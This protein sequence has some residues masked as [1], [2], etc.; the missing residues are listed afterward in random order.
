MKYKIK[1]IIILTFAICFLAAIPVLFSVTAKAAE[2]VQLGMP[3]ISIM[4]RDHA[5]CTSVEF[6]GREWYVIAYNGDGVASDKGTMTLLTKE[7]QGT[8]VF[9]DGQNLYYNDGKPRASNLDYNGST[10]QSRLIKLLNSFDSREKEFIKSRTLDDIYPKAVNQYLWPLSEMEYINI[11]GVIPVDTTGCA[12]WWLRSE[13][14][15]GVDIIDYINTINL[16]K[17]SNVNYIRPACIL[18]LSSIFLI[19]SDVGGKSNTTG[20]KL[21]EPVPAAG[22]LKFT[23]LNPTQHLSLK[24]NSISG[25][26]G[27]TVSIGYSGATTGANQYVSAMIMDENG[28]LIYYGRLKSVPNAADSE[29]TVQ[30]TL[31]LDF[32]SSRDKLKLFSEQVNGDH[33][34]DFA[35]SAITVSVDSHYKIFAV[36]GSGG[37]ISP[38]GSTAV[39]PGENQIYTLTP[40]Q[41]YAVAEVFVDDILID[42]SVLA[43]GDGNS[44][45]YTFSEVGKNHSIIATFAKQNDLPG[46]TRTNSSSSDSASSGGVLTSGDGNSK[47][48]TSSEAP[49]NRSIITTFAKQSDLP[50]TIRTNASSF[51]DVSSEGVTSSLGTSSKSSS[52]FDDTSVSRN[53]S[54][55]QAPSSAASDSKTDDSSTPIFLTWIAV[56]SSAAVLLFLIFRKRHLHINR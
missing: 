54:S 47:S 26:G 35:S 17:Y 10:L 25:W 4:E 56:I 3:V 21:S 53:T 30:V 1:K 49:E 34:S 16:D 36:A 18:D 31:P 23:F 44:K 43:S 19:S 52:S 38:S 50:Q 42:D 27:D 8:T 12:G 48:Y 11:H 2:Y 55:S 6:G 33:L 46:A 45:S 32:D 28:K 22:T 7:T 37:S 20:A 13:V 9:D 39:K 14:G 41:N 24:T 29:G 51:D 40:D 5:T 15:W